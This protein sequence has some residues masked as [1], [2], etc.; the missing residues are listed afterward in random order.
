MMSG[1]PQVGSLREIA[2]GES[3]TSSTSCL[4]RGGSGAATVGVGAGKGVGAAVGAWSAGVVVGVAI[5]PSRRRVRQAGP[6][7]GR[8]HIQ[9]RGTLQRTRPIEERGLSP[10]RA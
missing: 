3:S 4:S 1:S 9:A 2:M 6:C 8:H 10:S 5:G 7:F